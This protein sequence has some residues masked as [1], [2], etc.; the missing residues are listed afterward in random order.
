MPK[1]HILIDRDACIG[2]GLCTDK[3]PDVFEIDEDNMP[4]VKNPETKW[5]ENLVWLAKNCPMDALTIIDAETGQ[6]V[7]PPEEA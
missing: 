2:D 6:K 4:V 1:F 5:P 3:A 7:W